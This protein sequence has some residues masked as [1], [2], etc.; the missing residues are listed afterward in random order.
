MRVSAAGRPSARLTAA[1]IPPGRY[2]LVV[3]LRDVPDA[4]AARAATAGIA[5][6]VFDDS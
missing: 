3:L 4:E 1:G 2:L 5:Q 6:L